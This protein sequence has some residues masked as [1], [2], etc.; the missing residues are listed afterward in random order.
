MGE[1]VKGIDNR[2]KPEIFDVVHVEAV[3]AAG[4]LSKDPD[5]AAPRSIPCL[6]QLAPVVEF[7]HSDSFRAPLRQF[8]VLT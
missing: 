3:L 2:Q 4:G 6:N 8:D 5:H 7:E 1:V